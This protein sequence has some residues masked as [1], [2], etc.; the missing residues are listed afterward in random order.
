MNINFTAEVTW[1]CHVHIVCCTIQ[2]VQIEWVHTHLV[3]MHASTGKDINTKEI[4]LHRN[5]SYEGVSSNVGSNNMNT[6]MQP[7]PAYGMHHWPYE[8]N[9]SSVEMNIWIYIIFLLYTVLCIT[10]VWSKYWVRMASTTTMD[11]TL[12]I[13]LMLPCVLIRQTQLICNQYW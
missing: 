4:I 5:Q 12:V 7:C 9:V 13:E 3:Y 2:R 10:D 11:D 8:L 1:T 6:V